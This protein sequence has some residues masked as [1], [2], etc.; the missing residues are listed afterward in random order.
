MLFHLPLSLK[1][2]KPRISQGVDPCRRRLVPA[3]PSLSSS[4]STHTAPSTRP[5]PPGYEHQDTGCT[6]LGH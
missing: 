3:S 4:V 5:T 1:S 2:V 6:C